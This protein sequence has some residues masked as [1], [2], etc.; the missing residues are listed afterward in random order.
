MV[1]GEVP[2]RTQ[3]TQS[4]KQLGKEMRKTVRINFTA[5]HV[6]SFSY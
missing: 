2:G 3:I 4:H 5:T 6:R 1:S